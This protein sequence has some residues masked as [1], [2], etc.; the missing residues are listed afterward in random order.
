MSSL[1]RAFLLLD[2]A[3]LVWKNYRDGDITHEDLLTPP[4]SQCESLLRRAQATTAA[5]GVSIFSH[6]ERW[7]P[8]STYYCT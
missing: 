2:C 7:R 3:P 1:L 6:I 4:N 5:K 8:M